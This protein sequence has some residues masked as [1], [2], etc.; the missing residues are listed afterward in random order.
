MHS[1]KYNATMAKDILR[2]YAHFFK[3]SEQTHDDVSI[4]FYRHYCTIKIDVPSLTTFTT[5]KHK[6]RGLSTL[7]RKGLDYDM[8]KKIL[9]NPRFHSGKGSY[10]EE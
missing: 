9:E 8:I 5:L 6:K 3:W 7:K 10:L 1:H 4:T 2:A